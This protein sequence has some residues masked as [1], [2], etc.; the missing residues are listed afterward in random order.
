[1]RES[2]LAIPGE[3][4]KLQLNTQPLCENAAFLVKVNVNS[5]E[6]AAAACRKM[7]RCAFFGFFAFA[8]AKALENRVAYLCSS[9]ALQTV[10]PLPGW[11][12]GVKASL[13]LPPVIKVDVL[14]VQN[15]PL[16]P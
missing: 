14:P 8:A 5:V 9:D 10:G 3:D 7:S 11:V 13:P 4:F 12:T 2:S 1:M 15:G 6:E 16:L